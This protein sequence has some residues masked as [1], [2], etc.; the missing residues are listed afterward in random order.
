MS[1]ETGNTYFTLGTAAAEA[2]L[3]Y[4][5]WVNVTLV[6]ET[7][8]SL[9]DLDIGVTWMCYDCWNYRAEGRVELTSFE[10]CLYS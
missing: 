1:N 9:P 8:E 7:T 5:T 4:C 10:A 3:K 6:M 2:A